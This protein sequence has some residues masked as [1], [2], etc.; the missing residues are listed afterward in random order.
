MAQQ[1]FGDG[2][3]LPPPSLPGDDFAGALQQAEEERIDRA[4]PV[5]CVVC[6][7]IETSAP[8]IAFTDRTAL[9][10]QLEA[11]S[12]RLRA[13]IEARA[14]PDAADAIRMPPPS[15]PDFSALGE[16]EAE[17]LASYVSSL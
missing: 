13:A 5:S 12:G 2:L 3:Q 17:A 4:V 11:D 1:E 6:H 15:S 7:S 16:E 8:R 14:R 10:A 9:A